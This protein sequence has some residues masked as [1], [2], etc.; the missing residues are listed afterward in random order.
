MDCSTQASCPSVSQRLLTLMSTESVMTSNH[1][2][3][4]LS[5]PP[6]LNLSQHQGLFQWVSSSHQVAKVLEFQLQHQS[7]QY[8]FR[9]DLHQLSVNTGLLCYRSK[10]TQFFCSVYPV[11][12]FLYTLICTGPS[13]SPQFESKARSI[14]GIWH[15]LAL[16]VGTLLR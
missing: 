7:F 14:F 10:R 6:A 5:S 4:P 8:I 3:L 11:G 1:L 9:V 2:I 13:R 12:P 16:G 15:S